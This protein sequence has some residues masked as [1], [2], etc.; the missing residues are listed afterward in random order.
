MDKVTKIETPAFFIRGAVD[1]TIG[2]LR[3][4]S[5]P[6]IFFLPAKVSKSFPNVIV[7]NAESCS[8]KSL[9]HDN[10]EKLGRLKVLLLNDNEI[11]KLDSFVFAD[12]V[13][14]EWL[15]LR[16]QMLLL[17]EISIILNRLHHSTQ[18]TTT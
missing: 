16:K 9:S 14:L 15:V 10:F 3:F 18:I 8:V 6:N 11:E 1:E 5:N 7:Y 17:R 4:Y 13:S 2:G 12:L